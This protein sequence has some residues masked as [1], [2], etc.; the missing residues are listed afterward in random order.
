MA[1]HSLEQ[2]E[3]G[4]SWKFDP[5]VFNREPGFE[6]KWLETAEKVAT[7]PGRKAIVYGEQSFLFN[8]DSVDYMRETIAQQG[9][10]N[11][12]MIGIPCAR[13]HLM[14]DQPIAFAS[15]LRAILAIW[16]S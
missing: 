14:L 2:V 5:S 12:P 1:Y 15:T 6:K 4:W 16:Q 9:E 11:F 8:A 13:H 3:G 10:D 7:A